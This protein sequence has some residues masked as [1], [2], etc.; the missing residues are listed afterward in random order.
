MADFNRVTITQKGQALMAKIMAKS[1]EITFPSIQISDTSFKQ[2]QLRSLTNVGNVKATIIPRR[3]DKIDD[4]TIQVEGVITNE[5]LKEGYYLKTL[6][7]IAQDGDEEVIFAVASADEPGYLP[8]YNGKT[9]MGAFIRILIKVGNADNIEIKINPS[10]VATIKDLED[11]KKDLAIDLT[12]KL[13]TKADKIDTYTK[14]EVDKK[15]SDE[16]AKI[17]QDLSYKADKSQTFTKNEVNRLLDTKSDKENTYSIGYID[18]VI[19]ELKDTDNNKADKSNTFTK[20]EVSNSIAEAISSQSKDF[21]K[22]LEEKANKDNLFARSV[23]LNDQT[24]PYLSDGIAYPASGSDNSFGFDKVIT[25]TESPPTV[26]GD[27]NKL[28][29][30]I[31]A[32][33]NILWRVVNTNN[34]KGYT[35]NELGIDITKLIPTLLNSSIHHFNSANEAQQ[36]S[37]DNHGIAITDD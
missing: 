9:A 14:P 10:A 34:H 4:Q 22:K 28:Q 7:L 33:K 25:L 24:T 29:L 3:I 30:R 11:L 17:T 2:D 18:R 16:T 35:W 36:W 37:K 26:S 19:Q 13:A 21:D 20:T 12:N 8:S 1:K 6:G 15:F 27:V 5:G 32:G 31:R 23:V